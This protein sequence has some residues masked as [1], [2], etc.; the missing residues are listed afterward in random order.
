MP[1]GKS[2][3]RNTLPRGHFA[4]TTSSSFTNAIKLPK[5]NVKFTMTTLP[6][7]PFVEI[8]GIANFRDI[9]GHETTDG[10]KVRHGLVYR[11]ADPTKATEDGKKKMSE[12]L[13]TVCLLVRTY[14]QD[15][16]TNTLI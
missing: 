9:G 8:P 16:I 12:D 11:A 3:P 14:S 13:G 10:A 4:R 2:Q 6:S 15:H 1:V 5:D 7:P